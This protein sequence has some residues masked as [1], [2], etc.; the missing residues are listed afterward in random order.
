MTDEE[1]LQEA[2]RVVSG[3]DWRKT[4]YRELAYIINEV[5]SE[6]KAALRDEDFSRKEFA[7]GKLVGYLS[8]LEDILRLPTRAKASLPDAP[9]AAKRRTPRKTQ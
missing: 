8:A 6:K 4:P 2:S 1:I 9:A 5:A 3:M 7:C